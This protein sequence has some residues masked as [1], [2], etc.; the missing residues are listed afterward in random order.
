METINEGSELI[1]KN[2]LLLLGVSKSIDYVTCAEREKYAFIKGVEF[3]QRWIPV[4]EELPENYMDI[5]CLGNYTHTGK[6][7]YKTEYLEYGVS[8]RTK[9]LDHK[10]K[11]NIR[12]LHK[13]SITHWRP[14][15]RQ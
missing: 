4:E 3:A 14:I 13:K 9:Y 7:I 10:F 2:S 8:W 11:W 6:V 15:E 5:H 1:R 12:C